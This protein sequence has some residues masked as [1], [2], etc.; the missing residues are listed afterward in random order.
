LMAAADTL[1]PDD[2]RDCRAYEE[3]RTH[4]S[5]SDADA[6]PDESVRRLVVNLARSLTSAGDPRAAVSLAD[7][8][9]RR[10]RRDETDGRAKDSGGFLAMSQA[11]A[12][13]L[14]SC[15]QYRAAFDL[16]QG[17]LALMRSD[18]ARWE[19]QIMQLGRMA[20][21]H[22]R[23]SGDFSAALVADRES[24]HGHA[25]EFGRDNPHTF[26]AVHDV[27][28]DLAL[29]GQYSEALG[30]AR[31]LSDDC[32]SFYN[33]ASYPSVLFGRNVLGRC[34]WLNGRHDDAL[35]V[36]AEV[37]AHY[38]AADRSGVIADDHPWRLAHEIDYAVVRRDKG[39]IAADLE[40]LAS[41]MHDVRRRCW[42]TFGVD[43]PQ[44]LAAGVVLAGFL[45]RIEGRAGEAP[46]LLADAVARY[47]AL[48]PGHPSALAC[49]GYLASVRWQA[50]AGES[51][52]SALDPVPELTDVLARL[53]E[54][55]GASHP[56]SLA[57][58]A[59]LA[60]VLAETGELD[61][62]LGQA[63]RAVTM[64]R[65]RLGPDHPHSLACE[66]NVA[67]IRARRGERTDS[68]EMSARYAAVVGIGHPEVWLFEE[69][70][71][72]YLDF[73]PL[74]L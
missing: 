39:L 40:A 5:Q 42:R 59:S 9:L 16:G 63:E 6:C 20:G 66:A 68:S 36:M 64:F 65:D 51:E 47:E 12:E 24:A 48:L 71:L 56:F 60:N 29:N 53:G 10:W 14:L 27:I 33:D 30:A 22:C 3:L 49:R 41:H 73:T 58:R 34:C 4:A 35:K 54:A 46:R 23:V 57:A 74:P 32:L 19:A 50:A 43:H 1:R 38:T 28:T 13:A 67:T 72:V 70:R 52:R 45:K 7:R 62:A 17:T 55:A 31:R 21:A 69:G 26:A 2:P 8:T 61:A 18:P 15:G 37:H 11:K 44:T 25:A